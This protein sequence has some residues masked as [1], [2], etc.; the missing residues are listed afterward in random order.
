MKGHVDIVKFLTVEKHSMCRDNDENTPLH[1]AAHT[2]HIEVVKFL[3]LEMHCDPTSR[4][5][6]NGGTPGHCEI[7]YCGETL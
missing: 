4:N 7:P 5:A 3:T 1:N 2:G 6:N